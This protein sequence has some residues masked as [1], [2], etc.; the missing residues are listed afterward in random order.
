VDEAIGILQCRA[1]IAFG[2]HATGE[3]CGHAIRQ[4]DSALV[5]GVDDD[6]LL[7]SEFE[8]RICRRRACAAGAQLNDAAE[9]GAWQVLDDTL[10]EPEPVGV[11]PDS[12]AIAEDYRVDRRSARFL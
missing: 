6:E 1:H 3:H 9:S 4:R 5:N 12:T 8:R 10:P 11:V 2:E 7:C